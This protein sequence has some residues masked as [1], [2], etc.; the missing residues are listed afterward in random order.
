[1]FEKIIVAL[2]VEVNCEDLHAT[3][4]ESIPGKGPQYPL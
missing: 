1:M 3:Y 4:H 2:L